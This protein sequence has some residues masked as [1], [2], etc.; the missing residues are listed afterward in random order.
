M[1]TR[2]QFL[3]A[4]GAGA[5]ATVFAP[6]SL[7]DLA[8][9]QS[10]SRLLRGGRFTDGV[11][12]A[13][14]TTR[15]AAL[16][17][18]VD[19]VEGR[20]RVLLEVARDNDFRRVVARQSVPTSGAVNHAVKAQ[21]GGLRA[22]TEYFYRFATA[23]E[24]SRVGRFR[25]AAPADSNEPVKFAYFSCQDWTHGYYN[26]HELMARE[27]LDFVV[28]L[29]DY[30]YAETYHTRRGKT[31]VRDD[32]IGRDSRDDSHVREAVTLAD[33]RRKWSLYRSDEALRDVHARFPMVYV[34]DDHEVQD[35]YAGAERSGGLAP[36]K[37]YSA[38][39]KA[40]ARK[41]FFEANPRFPDNRLYRSLKFG[42]T[43]EL[44]TMDQR[45]FRK[46]QPCDDAV[47]PPCGELNQ[48]RAF[49]GRTQM[50]WLKDGLQASDASWKVLANEVT[51][52]PTLVL[53]GSYFAYD[54]WQGYP[55][56]RTEL[57]T[58]IRDRGIKDVVFVTGDIHTFIAGDVRVEVGEGAP[59]ALEFVGGSITSQGLGEI[60]LPAGNG[61]TIKGND[62]NPR[63]DP[64]LINALRDINPWVDN[65]DFDH[66]G[67]GVIEATSSGLESRFVRLQTIKRRSRA[68]VAGDGFTYRVARGQTSIKGVNGP[69]AS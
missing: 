26:A 39:R 29:G 22:H 47:A 13:D 1:P 3:S 19:D 18:R 30:I 55:G 4:A 51:M 65:A 42:K 12:S 57:L 48:P 9:G 63:T 62:Q 54:S 50:S 23:T 25:T 14:P 46:N 37:L 2:R 33:Y 15:G 21:V 34:P 24:D 11:I 27:D 36:D 53:G 35:N 28:C 5:A 32:R 64:S 31:G 68:R 17:T 8:A 61:V 66:H 56:E 6:Q 69:P 52:M 58:H 59:V 38:R 41:A 7:L 67:Y 40:A 49:L 20:G 44:F 45:S 60:D 16:W 43:V 10:R